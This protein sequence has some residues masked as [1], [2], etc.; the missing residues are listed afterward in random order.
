MY[1]KHI[2][3]AIFVCVF[4]IFPVVGQRVFAEESYVSNTSYTMATFRFNNNNWFTVIHP[5]ISSFTV[6]DDG[7]MYGLTQTGVPFTQYNV[8]NALD[9]RI[10]RF[11]IQDHYHY[12]IEGEVVYTPTELSARLAQV[13]AERMSNSSV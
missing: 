8:A 3:F 1:N 2:A 13:Y 11:E 7:S 10:Q 12:I 9:I 6:R 4:G 5:E